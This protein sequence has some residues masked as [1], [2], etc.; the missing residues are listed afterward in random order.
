MT[1]RKATAP[2][3]ADALMAKEEIGSLAHE[4]ARAYAE[5]ATFYR[6][7][8]DL[9][10]SQAE[11]SARGADDSAIEA[12]EDQARIAARPPDQL[13][14]WDFTRLAERDPA[15]M[16]AAWSRLKAKARDELGSGHRT[17]RA[18]E[19]N[20]RPWERAQFLAIRDSFRESWQPQNGIEAALLDTATHSFA[21]YLEWSEQ[22]HALAS[23]EAEG[24]KLRLKREG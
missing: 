14:W 19:W 12:A 3:D 8:M 18:L 9:P 7:Q 23:T 11:A 4:L 13:S 1:R 24:Y 15:A 6:D 5:M 17:A 22:L 20:G 10:A 21:D 2:V 16:A